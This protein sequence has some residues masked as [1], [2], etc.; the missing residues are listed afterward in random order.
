MILISNIPCQC[1]NTDYWQDCFIK[2]FQYNKLNSNRANYFLSKFDHNVRE[3][4]FCR[5]DL[6][7]C[8]QKLELHEDIYVMD[9]LNIW[10]RPPNDR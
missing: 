10:R 9:V 7:S 6:L 2:G 5:C 3:I 1:R 8:T 4:L